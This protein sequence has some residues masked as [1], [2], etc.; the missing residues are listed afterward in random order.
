MQPVGAGHNS[1]RNIRFELVTTP[2]HW[3]HASAIRSICF[4]EEHGMSA[5]WLFD[6]ND[7]MATHVVIYDGNEPI[8][9]ARVRFFKDFA[10]IERT[11][12]RKAYRSIPILKAFAAFGLDYIARKGYTR[13]ITHAGEKYARLW[14]TVLGFKSSSKEP[15][16]FEGHEPYY[17]IWKD[18]EP[19][20]DAITLETSCA[21]MFRTE[22]RW[23]EPSA[24]ER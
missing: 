16:Y 24:L 22:G 9:T 5:D 20:K 2:Q 18:I 21:V 19:A 6:G 1:E 10:K 12:F 14:K 11:S 15:A 8:G 17:E 7:Y 23:D 13:V 4:M 3:L